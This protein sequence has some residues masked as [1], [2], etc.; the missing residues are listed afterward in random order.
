MK[1]QRQEDQGI[2]SDVSKIVQ[3]E[4]Q[5][6]AT[7]M[8]MI[9]ASESEKSAMQE[10]V[11]HYQGVK[12]AI[13]Q[14]F[15]AE[16]KMTD[17]QKE[18]LANLQRIHQL[19]M[20]VAKAKSTTN[21]EQKDAYRQALNDLQQIHSLEMQIAEI[22]S[23]RD[24][25]GKFGD[26]EQVRLNA[27]ERE[28]ALTSHFASLDRS[29]LESQKL[30]TA[31]SNKQLQAQEKINA[32]ELKRVSAYQRIVAMAD[33]EQASMKAQASASEEQYRSLLQAQN[34]IARLQRDLIFAGMREKQIIA[35]QVSQEQQKLDIMQR[36][37]SEAGQLTE[38]RQRELQAIREQQSATA[39]LNETRRRAREKDQSYNDTGGLID[40]YSTY[41]NVKTGIEMVLQ[42]MEQ[43]DTAFYQVYKVANESSSV[44]DNFKKSTYDT[45]TSLGVTADEYMKAVETWIT[46]GESLA[47]S[48]TLAKISQIGSFVGN[49]APDDM[50][51]Y[52]SVPLKAFQTEGLK[53]ND[54]INTMNNTANNNAIEMD[55]LGKAYMRSATT[56]KTAG[57]SFQDL[58]GLI[59]AAQE[60]TRMG[61]ERIGT[62]LKSISMNYN[63]IKSQVTKQQKGKFAFFDSIGINL[64]QTTSLTDA[65]EKLHGK[66]KDLSK[67]QQTTAVFY[68]AGKEHANVLNGI[69]DQWD[70]VKQSAKEANQQIGKGVDGSAYIEFAQQS[71]SLRFKLAELKNK[72][73]ELMN[74]IG[75][76]KGTMSHI[77]Q[78]AID[79]L[80]KLISLSHNDQLMRVL[81]IL[82]GGLI[83]KGGINGV[84]RIFD[85]ISTG[86]KGSVRNIMEV[87]S[88]WRNIRR[89][90]NEATVATDRFNSAQRRSAEIS[91]TTAEANAG[92]M[93]AGA[94]RNTA[95]NTARNAT[96]EASNTTTILGSNG[97]A[98][99]SGTQEAER[100]AGRATK[101][102]S[103]VGKAIGK[104]LTLIPLLG[105]ALV[106]MDIMGI[107]VFDGIEK[108]FSKMFKST[109][110]EADEVDKL[111]KKFEGTNK[112]INGTINKYQNGIDSMKKTLQTANIM[113]SKGGAGSA[114]GFSNQDDYFKF[115]K[116]FNS[117]AKSMGAKVRITMN[118][119]GDIMKK[120][121]A[122]Q[123]QKKKLEQKGNVQIAVKI[124]GATAGS[125][126]NS[127]AQ[128][129]KDLDKLK[130]KQKELAKQKD[131]I[132]DAMSAM[133]DKKGNPLPQYI[134]QYYQLS[135]RL[136]SVDKDYKSTGKDIDNMTSKLKN[137]RKALQENASQLLSE[138][139]N[140][141]LTGIKQKNIKG[142]MDGMV[143]VYSK[144]AKN[145]QTLNGY[146]K[147]LNGTNEISHSTWAKLIKQVPTLE[148]YELKQVNNNK[149]IRK[150]V[151]D[152]VQAVQKDGDETLKTAGKA[153]EAGLKTSKAKKSEVDAVHKKIDAI[154]GEASATS[155]SVSAKNK[156]ASASNK[157]ASA[158]NKE[159]SAHNKNAS[160]SSKDASASN[161][162]ASAKNKDA[163]A[164]N[165]SASAKNKDA[166]ASNK[167]ASAKNKDASA[168]NKSASAKNKDASAS[169]KS[170]SASDKSAS[171]AHKDASAKDK[172]ASSTA[173]ATSNQNKL[174][175]A[176]NKTPK[177]HDTVINV[178]AD[179]AI[180]AINKVRQF[181][182]GLSGKSISVSA[183]AHT[184]KSNKSVAVGN[185]GISSAS[186]ATGSTGGAVSSGVPVL[187]LGGAVV[188]ASTAT[189]S[190]TNNSRV[191]EDVWRYW[192]TE[193]NQTR[194]ESAMKSLERAIT[195]AKDNQSQLIALYAKEIANY[196]EQQRNQN[197]LKGQK[198][199]Q[200]NDTLNKL[201]GYGFSVNTTTN[202]IS[203]LSHAKDLKG[204]KAEEAETLLNTWHSLSGE[205]DTINNSIADMGNSIADLKDK[206]QQANIQKELDGFE[207]RLK[208]IDAL[209]TSI[210]NKDNLYG[211]ALGFISSQDKELG[212]VTNE[213]A[214]NQASTNMSQLIDQFNLLSKS[215]INY[216]ENGTAL[217]DK[218]TTLGS[219]ILTQADNIIKYRQAIA[220][221]EFQRIT[222]D[223]TSVTNAIDQNVS[224]L[225]NTVKNLQD[226]LLSGTTVGDLYSS[227][228]VG[229]DLSRDNQFEVLAKERIAL[230]KEVDDAEEAFAKK[231]ID[232]V[233]GVANT[234][235]DVNKSMYN[236]LLTMQRDYT[237]GKAV[238]SSSITATYSNLGDIAT[239]DADYAKV[240]QELQDSLNAIKDEQDILLDEYNSYMNRTYDQDQREELTNQYIM[241]SMDLDVEYYKAQ[242]QANNDAIDEIN[243]ELQDSTLTDDQVKTRQDQIKT[244]EQSNIDTQNKIKDTVKSRF[245]FEFSLMDD[246]VAKQDDVTTSYQNTLDLI[247]A[248]GGDN[249]SAKGAL[250]DSLFD[251]EQSR[252]ALIKQNI[253]DLQDQLGLYEQ[254]SYEW[255]I[256]NDEITT[257]NKNLVDSNKNLVEMNKN[258]LSNEFSATT[259]SIEEKLFDGKSHDAWT[260]HQALWMSGLEKELALEK[261]YQRMAD[262]GTTVNKQKLDI[263]DK[264]EEVSKFEMDYLNKQLDI[265]ELQ[266]KVDNLNQ[267]RTVQVLQK[268]ADGSWDWSYQ[269]D[270]TELQKANE[271][272]MQAQIDLQDMEDKAKEDYLS[273]LQTILTNAQNG[274]YSTVQEFQDAM[275]DL[276]EAYK[277]VVGDIPE[278]GD[279]YIQ[280]LVESYAK[281]VTDNSGIVAGTP[282]NT[283][284]VNATQTMTDELRKTF[285][286][287]SSE[288][289]TIF[290]NAIL[291]KLPN[292]SVSANRAVTSGNTAISIDK[293][294]FPN[295]TSPTGIQEAI[296][297]LPQLAVQ[298]TKSKL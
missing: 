133:S 195:S 271:D 21:P 24:A 191:S 112:V 110:D 35:N 86:V 1:R 157:N 96:R 115:K 118:D 125:G 2:A 42:P 231:N 64:D 188:D 160:A 17:A 199:A 139:K 225:D 214:M 243:K 148:G 186:V 150:A 158:K 232:R 53:A 223:V 127:I 204:T 260:T 113:N 205:I 91:A 130:Q 245:D 47:D 62:A 194:L 281:F 266:Q 209:T 81:Q 277:Q 156:D 171:S 4:N 235:L 34:N 184:G 283:Y 162:S 206:I 65:I 262:L 155:K 54:I 119:T 32:Q 218:L 10:L 236:Q 87:D 250:Y 217:Q 273:Q 122:L 137:Q 83:L 55:D 147:D 258:I 31:E 292:T 80:D 210:T 169:H 77:L 178:I 50:V 124:S 286:D 48:Q 25:G 295:I 241:D 49:I 290:A 282:A 291:A 114:G 211:T 198:D 99:S 174:S 9:S 75:S 123:D 248:I 145:S 30:L 94:G 170:A 257:Y 161:K 11:N 176:I 203:N 182:N 230:E 215:T 16:K 100:S 106:V 141:D 46:A 272:L 220:D 269:A 105:D 3:L 61:G 187:G 23:R 5:I 285:T 256:I 247:T 153:I 74:S 142:T 14:T 19:Q 165:K 78:G 219:A 44:M 27:L 12:T 108:G 136:K 134:D 84:K 128:T 79:G 89:D 289:G 164:S 179:G 67:E 72:W 279:D 226:G 166:S 270:Q 88:A 238:S 172:Q 284:L 36:E 237:A 59:T 154:N 181:L 208:A 234:T 43:F 60:S 216:E 37:L 251:S 265:I 267:Q 90:I 28:L 143:G 98:I 68:L 71:D 159:A 197:V 66:W 224:R 222:D 189:S 221:L 116:E 40:P 239:T 45:A 183:T 97:R 109:K 58:T 190:D 152:K 278:I 69:I 175:G 261:M 293:L 7:K 246:L 233:Q 107:P 288:L 101:A 296:L 132:K 6:H 298:K 29:L 297:A 259:R 18:E 180:K 56:V 8:K 146:Q 252:N 15:N 275:K 177:K 212:L 93:L 13:E 126:K 249:F 52:M 102:I 129:I 253:S 85:T 168:S 117:E 104:T 228:S 103:G 111:N 268:Q 149:D 70:K 254:G 227:Q 255:N 200:L 202:T 131:S 138:G 140:L 39:K 185:T 287:M 51:K 264:Q 20:D 196:Q 173:K 244:Y 213:Q 201:K 229:L 38:A 280:Q 33:R 92:A 167:S 73:M 242:I 82:A 163:S 192:G 263:L 276:G 41:A 144:L 26:S 76:S 63:L 57:V 121:K 95:S 135:S 274:Q 207:A 151:M 240:N 120:M 22:E 193:D 294:E